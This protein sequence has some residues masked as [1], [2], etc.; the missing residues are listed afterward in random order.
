MF[1]NDFKQAF[2]NQIARLIAGPVLLVVLP[3][4]LSPE[5]QGY[6]FSIMGLA[7]LTLFAD[8][9]FSTL[10]LQFAAHEFAHLSFDAQKRFVGSDAQVRKMASLFVFA[11]KWGG[12]AAVTVFPV[13][14]LVGYA[15]LNKGNTSLGWQGPWFLYCLASVLVFFNSIALACLEG[16]NGVGVIQK[17]RY[18]SALISTAILIAGLIGGLELYALALAS[19]LSG[20]YVVV[21]IIRLFGDT[22]RQ[23][24]MLGRG[25]AYRWGKEIFPLLWKYAVSW[26]SGYFIFQMFT[27][28]A[29]YEYGPIEAGKVGLSIA[30][31]MAI[32]GIANT[33]MVIITPKMNMLMSERKY[34]ELNALF[35]RN[36][37]LSLLTYVAGTL[38]FFA[39]AW[40]FHQELGFLLNRIASAISLLILALI[41]LMQIPIN[42]YALY[43]RAQKMEP[44]M[45]MSFFGGVYVVLATLFVSHHFAYDYY[46]SG[47]LSGQLW[48]LPLVYMLYGKYR[49]V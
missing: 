23:I 44:M 41:W 17:I 7:A 1:N 6:W 47:F 4:Y 48:G 36:L 43:M 27:P 5:A 24:W 8:L 12:M 49:R 11:L 2:F 37:L 9:G 35:N 39:A 33:W 3:L 22:F 34:E 46:F 42:S 25:G 38:V 20:I 18:Q 28:L 32:F 40:L 30:I 15:V 14:A 13:I 10:I 21:R 45:Y 16:C 19:L 29:F 26:I 31:W